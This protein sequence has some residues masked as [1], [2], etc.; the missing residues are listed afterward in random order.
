MAA[1][2]DDDVPD[3]PS[4][5]KKAGDG[6]GRDDAGDTTA[7]LR[8]PASPDGTG[9]DDRTVRR[10]IDTKLLR[11]ER[12]RSQLP[13]GGVQPRDTKPPAIRMTSKKPTAQGLGV[14]MPLTRRT[15]SVPPP[16][17]PPMPPPKANEAEELDDSITATAPALVAPAGAS[18]I[19][20][21][22]ATMGPVKISQLG[23]DEGEG[24]ETEVRTVV[25][26]FAGGELPRRPAPAAGRPPTPPPAAADEGAEA[27]D[28]SVTAQAPSI[29]NVP[30]D[31]EPSTQP[32][33][34]SPAALPA[35]VGGRAPARSV[36]MYETDESV[37]SRGPAVADY[38]EDDDSVTADRPAIGAG[39]R[40]SA[41]P[42]AP[43]ARQG[44][45]RLVDEEDE[46]DHP[47]NHT[48]V[49][50]NAPVK[51]P[52][53]APLF[54]T[55]P[56]GPSPMAGRALAAAGEPSSDSGLRIASAVRTEAG[57]DHAS[58]A[59]LLAGM[60]PP[61][62]RFSETDGELRTTTAFSPLDPS[63]QAEQLA[64]PLAQPKK[65][66]Y[67]LIVGVVAGLSVL[68]PLILYFALRGGTVPAEPRTPAEIEPDPIGTSDVA[69][70]KATRPPPVTPQPPPPTKRPWWKGR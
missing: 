54:T 61:S 7:A 58:V 50:I 45:V 32:P 28:D 62:A 64:D 23:D 69:R 12:T 29:S 49:M 66:N 38:D 26:I 56:M 63:G 65:P 59:V 27:I 11:A 35:L 14:P 31:D 3:T 8:K 20:P 53:R 44:P 40:R 37:T 13:L 52:D 33:I 1:R 41:L 68:I 70:P 6:V 25:G 30:A 55:S 24:D 18:S 46:D 17:P 36:D 34:L 42:S 22:G 48:A 9:E 4:G 57:G 51:P 60:P 16:M 21:T 43:A 67:G 39:P 10:T 5:Q 2:S 15:A 19:V 47:H